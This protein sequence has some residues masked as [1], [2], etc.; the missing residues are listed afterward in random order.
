MA[1]RRRGRARPESTDDDFE[2]PVD[3]VL[4][5]QGVGNFETING[6]PNGILA[7]VLVV[8]TVILIRPIMRAFRAF[9][10]Q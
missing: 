3:P 7:A 6:M 5:S 10:R 9:L 8:L 2:Q 4:I 1:K